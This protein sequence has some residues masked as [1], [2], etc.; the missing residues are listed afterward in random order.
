MPFQEDMRSRNEIEK[1]KNERGA[2][3]A[4]H[5][6][7]STTHIPNRMSLLDAVYTMPNPLINSSPTSTS[8]FHE[9]YSANRPSLLRSPS[10]THVNRPEYFHSHSADDIHA[11]SQRTSSKPDQT[12]LFSTHLALGR[13]ISSYP[14]ISQSSSTPFDRTP[15][16]I[17]D[18][19]PR[20]IPTSNDPMF[21]SDFDE[22]I[23]PQQQYLARSNVTPSSPSGSTQRPNLTTEVNDLV[24]RASAPSLARDARNARLVASQAVTRRR[25]GLSL[26]GQLPPGSFQMAPGPT[27]PYSITPNLSYRTPTEESF[28]PA[29]SS[30]SAGEMEKLMSAAKLMDSDVKEGAGATWTPRSALRDPSATTYGSFGKFISFLLAFFRSTHSFP[31]FPSLLLSFFL[32]FRFPLFRFRLFSTRMAS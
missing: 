10:I 5:L 24:R 31:F 1:I 16:L 13:E 9:L 25:S 2:H 17:S 7:V 15:Q 21:R 3:A 8:Q 23:S 32:S 19:T 20:R 12:Q 30:S 29:S 6:S 22:Q 14:D 4:D 28:T 26:R 27:S 11:L 18:H